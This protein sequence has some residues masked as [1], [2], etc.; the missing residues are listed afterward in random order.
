[1]VGDFN[2]FHQAFA[3]C[4]HATNHQARRFKLRH[5]MVVHFIAVAVAFADLGCAVDFGGKAAL[6][7]FHFLRAQAHG[8][9]QIGV[10]VARFHAAICGLPFVNQR[11]N[12]VG[13]FQ[14]KLGGI[15]A[16]QACHIAGVFNQRNLHP[17]ANAQIGDVV[18]AGKT[19]GG[20]FAFHTARAKAARYKDGIKVFQAA[21][22]V[23]FQRF[24]V[25]ICNV[26]IG[27]RVNARVAQGFGERFVGLG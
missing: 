9:A 25:N 12:G 26:Y 2:R 21:C 3:P 19:G 4:G 24:A 16:C 8:A 6:L 13:G 20:D 5:I 1:M 18:L 11:D 15:C 10:F 14:V 17:Q 22:A 27:L 23:L 7:Q